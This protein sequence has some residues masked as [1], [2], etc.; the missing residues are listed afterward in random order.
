MPRQARLDAPG[1]L[2][3]VIVKGSEGR[4]IFAEGRDRKDFIKRIGDLALEQEADVA[5]EESLTGGKRETRIIQ[6]CQPPPHSCQR[7]HSCHP[8]PK[9]DISRPGPAA[10][11]RIYPQEIF[12]QNPR[13]I[14]NYNL[15]PNL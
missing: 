2:Q 6:F 1:I 3:H 10:F 4:Q 14:C 15:A 8:C 9:S 12:S 13:D 11:P 7:P 5:K